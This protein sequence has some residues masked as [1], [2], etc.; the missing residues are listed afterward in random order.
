M[1]EEERL[2]K[3]FEVRKRGFEKMKMMMDEESERVGSAL[4]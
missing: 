4:E 2:F 1:K 3:L